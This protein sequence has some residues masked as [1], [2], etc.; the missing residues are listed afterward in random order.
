MRPS[1]FFR[2]LHSPYAVIMCTLLMLGAAEAKGAAPAP[3]TAKALS[4]ICP[5]GS[6]G[7]KASK[8]DKQRAALLKRLQKI[9]QGGDINA[10]DDKGQTAL[11]SAAALN[12]RLAVCWLVAKGAD[13]NIRTSAGKSAADLATHPRILDLLKA[14]A[15]E[16]QLM[17]AD[18]DYLSEK[19]QITFYGTLGNALGNVI[20]NTNEYTVCFEGK[21]NVLAVSR[22]VKSIA[23][24][25]GK[26]A[27]WAEL[28]KQQTSFSQCSPECL[29]YLVR[30][31]YKLP[32]LTASALAQAPAEKVQLLVALGAM[33]QPVDMKYVAAACDD[34]ALMRKLIKDNPQLQKDISLLGKAQSA[35]MV[36]LFLSG[37]QR[38]DIGSILR[39][40]CYE[41]PCTMSKSA[42][43]LLIAEGGTNVKDAK[44]A[45]LLGTAIEQH[46]IGIALALI[47]AG[48]DVSD[49]SLLHSV[50]SYAD[51]PIE[52]LEA[53]IKAGANV[54]ATN[55]KGVSVLSR[56]LELCFNHEGYK[57]VHSPSH[58]RAVQLLLEAGA[59]APKNLLLNY[60]LSACVHR[61]PADKVPDFVDLAIKRGAD[62]FAKEGDRTVLV[63]VGGCHASIDKRLIEACCTEG[64]SDA[65]N[66]AI[67]LC[68]IEC[69][70]F[71]LA[72][73]AVFNDESL[74]SFLS[75]K[76][77][78]DD[79]LKLGQL[80]Q[81]HGLNISDPASHF[82][83]ANPL[84]AMVRLANFDVKNYRN[85][86]GETV[87]MCSNPDALDT[88]LALGGD[89]NAQDKKGNT[90]L[91][92]KIYDGWHEVDRYEELGKLLQVGIKTDIRNNEGKTALMVAKAL[93]GRNR[94]VANMVKILEHHGVKE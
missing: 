53:L 19:P 47:E 12:N 9:A 13:V 71:L 34:V 32:E 2:Y 73:G 33:I 88:F 68:R 74:N 35:E 76:C 56:A 4:A 79:T 17:P 64:L 14:C 89:I 55:H 30:Q 57:Y 92:Q 23:L 94:A 51:V 50:V 40:D 41:F 27:M 25:I 77:S 93:A 54:S 5:V 22:V 63:S 52:L 85:K 16:Q 42:A 44:N 26:D 72:K 11:M 20:E 28:D 39:L 37:A 60:E 36:R 58:W 8:T 45:S 84:L 38:P 78:I 65:L 46:Y 87:L 6:S 83:S 91:H 3:E 21:Q 49:E 69:V 80:L 67:S 48:A 15:Y 29:A 66:R 10:A 81:K 43:A 70:E 90:V 7:K 61:L 82:C 75:C 18:D 1:V 86:D 59:V 62:I 31:G 24:S